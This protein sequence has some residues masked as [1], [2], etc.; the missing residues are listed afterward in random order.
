MLNIADKYQAVK[1]YVTTCSLEGDGKVI[2]IDI[3]SEIDNFGDNSTSICF[4]FTNSFADIFLTSEAI[5]S[6]TVR[7]AVHYFCNKVRQE[8]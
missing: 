4:L 2:S 3:R 1:Y 6:S 7:L 8:V 5:F